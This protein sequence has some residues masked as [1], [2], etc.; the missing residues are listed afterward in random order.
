MSDGELFDAIIRHIASRRAGDNDTLELQTSL[1][2]SQGKAWHTFAT[3]FFLG[4]RTAPDLLSSATSA[5]ETCEAHYYI[6]IA[7]ILK[8]DPSSAEPEITTAVNSCPH[9]YHVYDLAKSQLQRL[10]K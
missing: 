5:G 6:G 4:K 9:E 2:A 10:K 1:D 8:G 3:E 7:H